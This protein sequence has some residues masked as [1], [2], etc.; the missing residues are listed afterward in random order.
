[1][2]TPTRLFAQT[3]VDHNGLLDIA[4]DMIVVALPTWSNCDLKTHER[5]FSTGNSKIVVRLDPDG[6]SVIAKWVWSSPWGLTTLSEDTLYN[7]TDILGWLSMVK[8]DMVV[9]GFKRLASLFAG[10]SIFPQG[11]TQAVRD[12]ILTTQMASDFNK[13]PN[14]VVEALSALLSPIYTPL[15]ERK[16]NKWIL[17]LVGPCGSGAMAAKFVGEKVTWKILLPLGEQAGLP[18][19]KTST[20]EK[21]GSF[22]TKAPP[23]S[24]YRDMPD[25]LLWYLIETVVVGY[26]SP[27]IPKQYMPASWVTTMLPENAPGWTT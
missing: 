11:E 20:V 10:H 25:I 22:V 9:V 1:M 21:S 13:T 16:E 2:T 23:E 17:R 14:Q 8:T 7:S 15:W 18:N 6:D 3:L 12:F 19:M 27:K 4:G 24:L 5:S 26:L